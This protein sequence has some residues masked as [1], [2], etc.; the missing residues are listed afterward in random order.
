MSDVLFDTAKFTLRPAARE[1]LAKVA[2]IVLAHPGL[3]LE[4]EGHTDSVG[5]DEYNQKLSDNRAK[6]VA[7]F[8][9][10][11][12]LKEEAITSKGFG[13][14]T[15]V[16]DNTTATGRQQNRRVELI[17]SGAIIEKTTTLSKIP[18]SNNE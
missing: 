18:S 1:K 4:V 14:S 8:L 9:I 7:D 3:K 12:G 5:S 17:V 15:P 2:G 11:Q 13:E 16:A 10:K 6:S